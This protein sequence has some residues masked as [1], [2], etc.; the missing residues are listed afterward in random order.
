MA[1]HQIDPLVDPRWPEFVLR[2][3][4]SSV[5]HTK[6]WLAALH[7]TYGYQPIA[8]TNSEGKDLDHA[9]VFCKIRSSLTGKRL[10][11]LPFSDHCQP[12][13]DQNSIRA[14]IHN[15]QSHSLSRA[16]RYIEFRP[17]V[18]DGLS[19]IGN[20]SETEQFC[21]HSI[22]LRK[23]IEA[24]YQ[25][26]HHS[27]IRRKIKRAEKEELIY[28]QGASP[29]LVSKFRHLFLLTR[30][31]HRLPPPPA[32]WF[33]NLV[34]FLG[35]TLKIHMVSKG[36]TPIASILT[37]THKDVIV[38]KY[39]CSDASFSNMGGTPY[40]FWTVIQQA[41]ENG[42]QEFDLGRSDYEDDGLIAFKGH[43]GATATTL[44]YLRSSPLKARRSA[45]KS[46]TASLMRYT[47]SR[48]PDPLLAGIG[49]LLYR[50]MG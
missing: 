38:Y 33:N 14:I 4:Q 49:N 20:F 36:D 23:N 43:L 31:R 8:F 29:S 32:A 25:G 35:D 9:V 28:E 1:L 30:R 39:G 26:M 15:L 24:L 40:L 17:L 50:H 46:G 3:P 41:K 6:G 48:L 2:H 5:F 18:K 13:A 27:C 19:S 16:M 45:S 47:M 10:V 22:D 21:F 7:H 11:S 34:H 12:L 42:L 37:L 44:T